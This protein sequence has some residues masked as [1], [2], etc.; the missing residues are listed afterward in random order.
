MKST[1]LCNAFA[2]AVIAGVLPMA[3]PRIAAAQ[4]SLG[5][6]LLQLAVQYEKHGKTG[7][8][9]KLY[10]RVLQHNRTHPYA[11]HRLGVL[12]ARRGNLESA[13]AH[14]KSAQAGG[15]A[16]AELLN[17]Y[18]AALYL[19]ND[20]KSAEQKLQAALALEP[21]NRQAA[22]NL[23]M[24]QLKREW[25]YRQQARALAE[26]QA[27]IQAIERSRAAARIRLIAEAKAAEDLQA[28]Q[29]AIYESQAAQGDVEPRRSRFHLPDLDLPQIARPELPDLH[30]PKL[31]RPKLPKLRMPQASLPDWD[32]PKLRKPNLPDFKMPNFKLPDWKMPSLPKWKMP[33]F[34]DQ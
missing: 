6:E 1:L 5:Q 30:L 3:A 23:K 15:A 22:N 16:S 28:A 27:A 31:R 26:D 8:A 7:E 24:V 17:D 13:L 32:L 21:D 14:F 29:Q 11:H 20:L 10:Y 19:A 2:A 9:E 33:S 25:R 18:G 34:S 12:A 4:N